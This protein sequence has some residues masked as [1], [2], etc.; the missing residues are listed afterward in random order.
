MLYLTGWIF[1]ADTSINVSLSQRG[2]ARSP[3]GPSSR[4]PTAAA[5]GR[6]RSPAMGYPAGKTKTMPVDLSDVL[7]RAD[8]RVRI[9]T[10]LAIYWDRIVVHGRRAAGRRCG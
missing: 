3:S 8:P 6:P 9:R 2:D 7:D 10:N 1:Y 4:C 5:A